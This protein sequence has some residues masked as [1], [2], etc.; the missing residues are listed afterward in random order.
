MLN[1]LSIWHL[2]KVDQQQL[3]LCR[4]G[5]LSYSVLE[6][7]LP[8]KFDILI[9]LLSNPYFKPKLVFLFSTLLNYDVSN[10]RFKLSI[11]HTYSKHQFRLVVCSLCISTISGQK[12]AFFDGMIHNVVGNLVQTIKLPFIFIRQFL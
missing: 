1:I 3:I 12:G 8:C 10:K 6:Q 9:L 11:V 2:N 4:D 7:A 5:K